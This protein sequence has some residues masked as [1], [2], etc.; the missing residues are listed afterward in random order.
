[1]ENREERTISLNDLLRAFARY[2]YIIASTI[3][4]GVIVTYVLAFHLI[5]PKYKASVE[6]MVKGK[7][8]STT[9]EYTTREAFYYVEPVES[10]LKS[11]VVLER[12][13]ETVNNPNIVVTRAQLKNGISTS[14]VT[15]NSIIVKV[16]FVHPDKE[17]AKIVVNEIFN[18]AYEISN[19]DTFR[20]SEILGG[21]FFDMQMASDAKYHSPNKTLYLI[22]GFL[23]G[24]IVG[25]GIVL[26][27]DLGKATYRTKEQI[28][29]D[30][31]VEVIG[32]IPEFEGV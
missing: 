5:T 26:F 31:E 25:A 1:M 24:G 21:T 14:R 2:W 12:V 27:I 4:I 22:V 23:L 32:V 16:S 30:L 28:E 8:A 6:L 17:L 10:L 29:E 11:D 3:L 9:T 7:P 18:A 15:T 13:Y 19:D 20:I